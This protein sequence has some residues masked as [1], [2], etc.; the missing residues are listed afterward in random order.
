MKIIRLQQAAFTLFCVGTLSACTI[1]DNGYFVKADGSPA[2]LAGVAEL[3]QLPPTTPVLSLGATF[4]TNGK[5]SRAASDT[6]YESFCTELKAR[7]HWQVNRV[8]NAGE[9]FTTQIVA[10]DA[11][12]A[13]VAAPEESA[14]SPQKVEPQLLVLVED[15]PDTSAATRASYLVSGM[16]YGTAQVHKPTDRYD[17]TIAYRDADGVERVYKG[18]QDLIFATGSKLFGRDPSPGPGYKRY[19]SSLAAFNG[20]VDNSVNGT[21]HGKVTVGE[22]MVEPAAAESQTASSEVKTTV[23]TVREKSP[24]AN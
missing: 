1:S 18:H 7:G 12:S 13:D 22:A 5:V 24:L 10:A 4:K 8:G 2:T 11:N 14:P 20:V 15:R 21:R 6:L 23:A 16:T 3:A 19:E 17:V 9:D